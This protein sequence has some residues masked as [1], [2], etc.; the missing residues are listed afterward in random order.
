MSKILAIARIT[1]K[2]ELRNKLIYILLAIALLF[3]FMARGCAPAKINIEKGLISADQITRAGMLF[4]FNCILFWGLSLCGLLAMNAIPR[5]LDEETVVLTITK[6][7]KRSWFL[8]GK[9]LGIFFIVFI[10][11]I[12]LTIGFALFFYLRSGTFD[13]RIFAVLAA[14]TPNFILVISLL[15]LLSLVLP[16]AIGA[17]LTLGIYATSL[18]LSVLFFFEKVRAYW[19]PS[20]PTQV[21]HYALP[22]L[23]GAHLYALSMMSDAFPSSMGM[24]SLIDIA[25]YLI[26][27]WTAMLLVFQRKAL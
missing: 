6:P 8:A 1:V 22:Q 14:V 19:E 23:G 10:N 16:R 26:I 2:A 25:A 27:I 5:E 24:W 17:L 4:T 9:F 21:L 11:L 15:F 20:L 3:L 12:A 13:P 7:V 18:W